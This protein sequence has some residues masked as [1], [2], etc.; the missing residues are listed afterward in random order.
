MFQFCAI[1]MTYYFCAVF[2]PRENVYA[3]VE[4]NKNKKFRQL[5]HMTHGDL[6]NRPNNCVLLDK[7]DFFRFNN[8]FEQPVAS[9]I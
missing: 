2:F 6:L 3:M 4:A 5:T 1:V 8:T 9:S 7:I